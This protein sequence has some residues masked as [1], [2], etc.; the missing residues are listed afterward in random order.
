MITIARRAVATTVVVAS[1]CLCVIGCGTRIY[2]P[3][4]VGKSYTFS[5]AQSEWLPIRMQAKLQD[6]IACRLKSSDYWLVGA[7]ADGLPTR[8]TKSYGTP[9]PGGHSFVVSMPSATPEEDRPLAEWSEGA[10]GVLDTATGRLTPV[11]P[12][13][14]LDMSAIARTQPDDGVLYAG[15]FGGH[16]GLLLTKLDAHRSTEVVVSDWDVCSGGVDVSHDRELAAKSDHAGIAMGDGVL[17]VVSTGSGKVILSRDECM[18]EDSPRSWSAPVFHPTDHTLAYLQQTY[19]NSQSDAICVTDLSGPKPI[20]DTFFLPR[21]GVLGSTLSWSP[22]GRYLAAS[23]ECHWGGAAHVWLLDL[24]GKRLWKWLQGVEELTWSQAPRSSARTSKAAAGQIAFASNLGGTEQLYLVNDDASGLRR[25]TSIAQPDGNLDPEMLDDLVWSPDGSSL[26]FLRKL[27]YRDAS[28]YHAMEMYV[29]QVDGST[30]PR[31]LHRWE[32]N[33]TT[34]TD[35]CLR[36][37]PD[38][39]KLVFCWR[40]GDGPPAIYSLPT[41]GPQEPQVFLRKASG[42][43]FSPD[44]SSIA[45][46]QCGSSPDRDWGWLAESVWVAK[47]D[48]GSA[49]QVAKHVG[50]DAAAPCW[51]PDGGRLAFFHGLNDAA[52]TSVVSVKHSSTVDC[53]GFLFEHPWSPDG[54]LLLGYDIGFEPPCVIDTASG[55]TRA[56]PLTDENTDTVFASCEFSKDGSKVVFTRDADNQEVV[57][58]LS[59]NG[60]NKGRMIVEGRI[61]RW[62][63]I[64]APAST[65]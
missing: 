17:T 40:V 63:P 28:G 16:S 37:T 53:G 2:H 62:R 1:F 61:P 58:V 15:V 9:R 30:E 21:S 22:D 54:K 33:E 64:P 5:A 25:L 19:G 57:G 36:W 56:L 34:G 49:R 47:A 31:L 8:S 23:A 27:M 3:Q 59:L 51:S 4:V 10:V 26:A 39:T 45:Y 29:V 38:S 35:V 55:E 12:A 50:Y 14:R 20:T 13:G 48:G 44:G 24:E 7:A 52:T 60:S 41:D 18:K 11:D 32:A 6:Q 42:L 65:R 46:A 43:E